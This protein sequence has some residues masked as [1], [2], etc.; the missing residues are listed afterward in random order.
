MT[1][2]N[3]SN[4]DKSSPPIGPRDEKS[5]KADEGR[6]PAIAVA[7]PSSSPAKVPSGLLSPGQRASMR[8]ACELMIAR[9][10]R[11][12]SGR[13]H[14]RRMAKLARKLGGRNE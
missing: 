4:E 10:H 9:D 13:Q 2:R 3:Q 5:A 11:A 1:N 7:M 8:R 12:P 6:A 14:R